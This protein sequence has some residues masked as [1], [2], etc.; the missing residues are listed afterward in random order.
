MLK[1]AD[2]VSALNLFLLKAYISIQRIDYSAIKEQELE[3]FKM[4]VQEQY[5]KILKLMYVC[6]RC[7]QEN[8][9]SFTKEVD[10]ALLEKHLLMEIY[11][12]DL[13]NL[14]KDGTEEIKPSIS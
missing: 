2:F 11:V 5:L 3:A 12:E 13:Y 14:G 9:I 4:K 6:I 1:E 7:E 8:A 10:V